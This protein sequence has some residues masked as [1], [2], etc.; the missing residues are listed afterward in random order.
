MTNLQAAL[1]CGQLKNISWIIKR[2]K[3][4]GKK[5]YSLLKNNPKIF[6][7]KIKTSYA[8]NIFW[9]F[10]VLIK[11]NS[12]INR[13]LLVK[14][15]MKNNIQ[16]RNFFF[17]M[18]KQKIFKKINIFKGKTNYPNAEYLSKNGF[19]LPSGLG[20]KNQEISYI[21]KILNKIL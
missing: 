18:H 17:P 19:Y 6:I 11:K 4:I 14:K 1:G 10:G 7:Q 8:D 9:V 12:K 3:E 5:Y 2:K 21:C 15:L 16:T 13:D 20:I